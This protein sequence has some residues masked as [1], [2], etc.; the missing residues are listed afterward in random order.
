MTDAEIIEIVRAYSIQRKEINE[1]IGHIEFLREKL[2]GGQM[3]SIDEINLL[4]AQNDKLKQ[5]NIELQ[6][7]IR[8]LNDIIEKHNIKT[9]ELWTFQG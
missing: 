8:R 6:K 5:Q 9:E 3:I 7:E 1:L 2:K 4:L